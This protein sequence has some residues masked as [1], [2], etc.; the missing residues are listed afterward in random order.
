MTELLD[1]ASRHPLM[2]ILLGLFAVPT[3]AYFAM[4]TVVGIASGLGSIGSQTT[5]VHHHHS[6]TCRKQH[7]KGPCKTE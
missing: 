3:V 6:E 5:H 1:W 4:L 7:E 2:A